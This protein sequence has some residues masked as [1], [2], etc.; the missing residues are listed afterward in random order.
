MIYTYS[1]L[2]NSTAILRSDEAYIPAD[3]ANSDYQQYLAWVAA[4]NTPTAA[5]VAPPPSVIPVAAFWARF[6]PLE[7]QAIMT[8]ATS[9][10]A[11]SV[12]MSF[13]AVI[14]QVNLLG[15]PI[16]TVWMA[17]LVANGTITAARSAQILTP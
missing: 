6:T 16:V 17:G 10:P 14:G 4:G 1:L 11:L 13:A 12:P 8:A 3:P 9:N 5:P 7:Q 15:G 2:A